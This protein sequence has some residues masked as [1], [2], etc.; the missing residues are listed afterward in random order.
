MSEHPEFAWGVSVSTGETG[1]ARPA[2][3]MAPGEIISGLAGNPGETADSLLAAAGPDSS[4]DSMTRDQISVLRSCQQAARLSPESGL[5]LLDAL[6]ERAEEHPEAS[7]QLA[8][9]VLL[10]LTD[11]TAVRE[12]ARG[13]RNKIEALAPK[14]WEA[15]TA[16]WDTPSTHSPWRG[17]LQETINSWPGSLI[18][19]SV[20]KIA[21]QRASDPE[22][23]SCLPEPDRRFL[24]AAIRGNTQAA[25]LAQAACADKLAILH[26]DDRE[27]AA[28]HLLPLM[29]PAEDHDRALRCWDAYLPS[30]RWNTELL[31]D[32]LFEHFKSICGHVDQF[33]DMARRGFALQAADLCLHNGLEAFG[34]TQAW[35]RQFTASTSESTRTDFIR[36]V[37]QF[38]RDQDPELIAGQWHDWMS[39]YWEARIGG[40]PR[41]PDT[42]EASALADWAIL[43][44]DDFPAAAEMARQ[45]GA[46]FQEDSMLPTEMY[47]AARGIGR[48]VH[49][50]DNHPDTLA[51]HV[52]T[53]LGNT[54]RENR[55]RLDTSMT[56]LI[57]RL[58]DLASEAAFQPLRD[59]AR[60]H[61]WGHAVQ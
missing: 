37:S 61:G 45:S 47:R 30:R 26:T 44:D 13:H 34:G 29:D 7:G 11:S 46:S 59:Q 5:A 35:L 53:L 57:R 1:W 8:A 56:V 36:S 32:G 33:S 54:T 10:Q 3:A 52:A 27:W 39:D 40:L 38:L 43:L 24:E 12:T 31:Q 18:A 21:A 6:A 22:T 50:L 19:L 58:Q 16:H 55:Q 4:P 28:N 17:W 48:C 41:R 23:W 14:L 60:L 49:L 42:A 9:A 25:K 51:G 15:G 2:E 20:H